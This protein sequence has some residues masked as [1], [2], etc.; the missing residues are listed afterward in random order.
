MTISPL[1]SHTDRKS[2]KITIPHTQMKITGL[3]LSVKIA[4]KSTAAT[5]KAMTK[6][7]NPIAPAEV[8][9]N[10]ILIPD[11]IRMERKNNVTT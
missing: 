10:I 2:R 6:V 1:L 3:I 4:K 7:N 5:I 9:E 11:D 8:T